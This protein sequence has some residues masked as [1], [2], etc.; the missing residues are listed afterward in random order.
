MQPISMVSL[1]AC[2]IVF[3]SLLT[4]SLTI[5]V[6][7]YKV[8]KERQKGKYVSRAEGISCLPE[9]CVT[10]IK[11]GLKR[12]PVDSRREPFDPTIET[13]N[14]RFA[15][16]DPRTP[17]P[18]GLNGKTLLGEACEEGVS[19]NCSSKPTCSRDRSTVFLI[20]DNL[21][22]QR[23]IPVQNTPT[24]DVPPGYRLLCQLPRKL[25]EVAL[26]C[27]SGEPF[28]CFSGK[29]GHKACSYGTA[30][31]HMPTVRVPESYLSVS[32]IERDVCPEGKLL[33]Y[34]PKSQ[35]SL[36]VSP[37]ETCTAI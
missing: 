1:L 36:C 32:C 3:V 15:C 6:S 10:N 34:D 5:Y 2:V 14:P 9:Y 20:T 28:E 16:T 31:V 18:L 8:F 19:C 4:I 27:P 25:I 23:V 33:Y 7:D 24:I 12:C 29:A 26:D 30:A 37:K 35:T 21:R 17:H 13:C 22:D 11:S